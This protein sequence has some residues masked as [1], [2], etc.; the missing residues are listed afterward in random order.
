M[1]TAT[2]LRLL[3]VDDDDQLRETLVRRFQRQGMQVT[4]AGTAEEALT[5]SK[6]F[7]CDVALLDLHLPGKSGIELLEAL[8][9]RQ[10]ELEAIMF[11]GHGSIETAIQAMKRGAYD[12][13]TK[14]FQLPELEVYLQKAFEKV[15]LVRRERQWV[16]QIHF[17]S[18]RYR[19][20]GSSSSMQ[21][22]RQLI[23]KVAPTDATVLVC[24]ASGT[25]KERSTVRPCKRLCWRANYSATKKVLSPVQRRRRPGWWK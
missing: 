16:E 9:E 15:Q 13:L 14:P 19:L 8:R 6:Q 21:R 12:Y 22:V 20:V 3:I 2:P 7:R 24:G 11:T 25:G 18:A 4:G 1:A 17:E 10:P 5:K 23:E